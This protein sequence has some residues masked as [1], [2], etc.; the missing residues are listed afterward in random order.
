MN[1][2]V[3]FVGITA[4]NRNRGAVDTENIF[5]TGVDFKGVVHIKVVGADATKL[6]A[7]VRE[8]KI[9]QQIRIFNIIDI[10]SNCQFEVKAVGDAD[11]VYVRDLEGV[12]SGRYF[13]KLAIIVGVLKRIISGH[14]L[15]PLSI[16]QP[17]VQTADRVP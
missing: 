1:A 4:A 8:T 6:S 9:R 13:I 2:M 3:R 11:T 5:N 15:R 10:G 16:D 12:F 17:D 7:A 14:E